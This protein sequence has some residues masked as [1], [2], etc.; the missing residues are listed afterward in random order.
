MKVIYNPVGSKYSFRRPVLAIGVFDGVHI[1][2]RKLLTQVVKTAREIRGTPMVMTFSPHPV[3]V[4]HP[5]VNLPLISSLDYRLKLFQKLG[6]KVVVVVEFTKRFSKLSP[7]AF[8]KRYLHDPFHPAEIFVG[9]DFRFGQNRSGSIEIFQRYASTHGFNVCSIKPVAGE[10]GKVS[11]TQIRHYIIKGNLAKAKR[12][13][14]HPVSLVGKVVRGDQRGRLLGF[15]TANIKP[16]NTLLPPQGVYAVRVEIGNQSYLG[17]TNIGQRPSFTPLDEIIV[18][19]NIFNFR[20]N[21][22]NKNITLQFIKKIRNERAFPSSAVLIQ[23]LQNDAK[24]AK[25]ILT[26][27]L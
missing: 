24:R 22:Y 26:A 12:F 6:I 23:Q 19:T 13:L 10:L 25:Q 27:S 17:M 16:G 3:H 2:H 4:L 21:L 20:G 9:D 8:I 11:S 7:A 14:G 18:E 5:E 15:P 1:G